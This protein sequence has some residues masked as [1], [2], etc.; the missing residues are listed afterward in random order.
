MAT[1]QLNLLCGD[2]NQG[3]KTV[4]GTLATTNFPISFNAIPALTVAGTTSAGHCYISSITKT[5]F[6]RKYTASTN[7][8]SEYIAA[9]I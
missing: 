3:G 1:K 6:E 7:S 2:G 8:S 5:S 4:G 9:G